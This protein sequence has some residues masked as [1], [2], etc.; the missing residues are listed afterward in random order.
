MT[1]MTICRL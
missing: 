1:A